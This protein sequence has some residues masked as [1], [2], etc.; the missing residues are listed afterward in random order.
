MSITPHTEDTSTKRSTGLS[1]RQG[2]PGESTELYCVPKQFLISNLQPPC[3]FLRSLRLPPLSHYCSG[4]KNGGIRRRSLRRRRGNT[5]HGSEKELGAFRKAYPGGSETEPGTSAG[6]GTERLPR[7]TQ[8]RVA[9]SE[10]R[11]PLT[12]RLMTQWDRRCRRR[13]ALGPDFPSQLRRLF[14]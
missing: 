3:P 5:P 2:I 11:R 1:A 4:R 8:R 7:R 10:L 14:I 13:R 6:S 12:S 9:K